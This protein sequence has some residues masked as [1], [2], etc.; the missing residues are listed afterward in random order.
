MVVKAC[1]KIQNE[2]GNVV[3]LCNLDVVEGETC[4]LGAFDHINALTPSYSATQGQQW[5]L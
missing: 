2:I 4:F 1:S 3:G 5:K